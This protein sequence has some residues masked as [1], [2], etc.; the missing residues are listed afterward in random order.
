MFLNLIGRALGRIS[1]ISS[2]IPSR[3]VYA[4]NRA[5]N[6]RDGDSLPAEWYLV[7]KL[8]YQAVRSR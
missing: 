8:P 1:R 5:G 4:L 2:R 3:L 6:N 7:L